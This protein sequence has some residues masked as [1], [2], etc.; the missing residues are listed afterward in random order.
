MDHHA[1]KKCLPVKPA[2]QLQI[3]WAPFTIR[4]IPPFWQ[5]FIPT[6]HTTVA[7]VV[8]AVVVVD[9]IVVVV[10][11]VVETVDISQNDPFL[12]QI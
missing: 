7:G 9:V 1:L 6:G 4:H 12:I 3:T 2:G 8:D 10:V 11:V 5:I